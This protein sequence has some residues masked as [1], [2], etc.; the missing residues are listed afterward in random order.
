MASPMTAVRSESLR[1]SLRQLEIFIAVASTGTTAEAG[2][3]LAMSQSAV[4]AALKALEN[5]HNAELFDRIANRLVLNP[6]GRQ[7]EVRARVLLEEARQLQAELLL[8]SP[9]G[10]LNISASFTIA[11]HLMVDYLAAWLSRYP[12]AKVDITPGNTPDVVTRI[13]NRECELGLIENETQTKG[14]ELIPW[15]E[16][17]LFAFCAPSHPLAKKGRL[18]ETDI[19][20]V[21]W[22][23]REP[24][25]GARSLFDQVFA[26]LVPKLRV[27]LEL[28]HNEP[29]LRAVEQEL[30]VGCLSE[31]VLAPHLAQGALV[32]LALPKK[33][34][35]RRKFYFCQ[36]RQR[37]HRP[38]VTEFLNL[39]RGAQ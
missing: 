30:G 14:V 16:D 12:M 24:N 4:S 17:E 2:Q 28:R 11:N 31:K 8:A 27:R 34:R 18:T 15:V 3:V 37:H 20:R 29:I 32:A 19:L 10:D 21:D 38:E 23:L 6:T 25:S 22:I 36:R 39:C 7:L 26:S 13:L 1:F 5:N 9:S 33:L 35:L